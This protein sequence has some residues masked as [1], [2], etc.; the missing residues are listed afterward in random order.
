MSYKKN[1][2]FVFRRSI[3]DSHRQHQ[4]LKPPTK[5][6]FY[7]NWFISKLSK[8]YFYPENNDNLDR[9]TPP[10]GVI[11]NNANNLLHNCFAGT[12]AFLAH[13]RISNKKWKD[14]TNSFQEEF[15]LKR[16]AEW[17]ERYSIKIEIL[18]FEDA[19]HTCRHAH[20]FYHFDD[21]N[22]QIHG[23]EFWTKFDSPPS[24]N[25]K[26][27]YAFLNKP[28]FNLSGWEKYMK[29]DIVDTIS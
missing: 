15:I 26:P 29:K 27:Q 11:H 19:D 5:Y 20:F 16:L 8:S 12:V 10:E 23:L 28:V 21:P 6:Q 17:R 25:G 1:S 7:T 2:I 18:V 14:H 3:N 9:A 22:V 24:S 4:Y 13:K